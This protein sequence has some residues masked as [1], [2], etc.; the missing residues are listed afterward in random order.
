MRPER[1]LIRAL[2]TWPRRRWLA[3]GAIAALLGAAGIAGAGVALGSPGWRV[4]GLVLGATIGAGLGGLLPLL[5]YLGIRS[6]WRTEQGLRELGALINVRPLSGR[7]PLNL[8]GWPADPVLMDIVLRL[9]ADRN[10][11]LVV[12]C[13]SGWSTVLLSR[14]LAELG[15]GHLVAFEHDERFAEH[16]RGLLGGYGAE[17]RAHVVHA[18]LVEREVDGRRRLWYGHQVE[19]VVG[20]DPSGLIGVLLV[21][22]PP[23]GAA[24]Q[25][26]YPAVPVLRSRLSKDVVVLLDDGYREDEAW[27]A[28]EW[29]RSLGV[30]PRFVASG[31]GIWLLDLAWRTIPTASAE[32]ARP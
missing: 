31:N 1:S 17:N 13:G 30:E 24:P 14:C 9:L 22:G 27:T 25:S 20:E 10:P 32:E 23:A 15:T 4:L 8:G 2:A 18:P 11:D 28:R 6:S 12:E 26:R 3:L 5:L 7:L 29:G 21:D 19:A 16:T